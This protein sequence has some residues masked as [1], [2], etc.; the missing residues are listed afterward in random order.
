M[1]K[2]MKCLD[3]KPITSSTYIVRR[4]DKFVNRD[5]SAMAG[6]NLAKFSGPI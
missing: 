5:Y 6:K 4:H 3:C 2:A 1:A